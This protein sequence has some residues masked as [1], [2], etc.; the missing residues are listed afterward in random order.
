MVC[1]THARGQSHARRGAG[2]VGGSIDGDSRGPGHRPDVPDRRWIGRRRQ[3]RILRLQ[4]HDLL[5]NGLPAGIDAFT[6]AVLGGIGSLPG[7]V[8][9]GL[10]IGLARAFCDQ[11]LETRWTNVLVFAVLIL[12]LVFR[13]SGLLGSRAK[14]KV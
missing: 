11:Y 1:E 3:R 12:V 8:L 6:A 2:P 9:G 5:P 13:P 14:E 7:A 10:V 4:Q